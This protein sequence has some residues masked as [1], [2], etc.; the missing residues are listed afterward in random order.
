MLNFDM[1]GRLREDQLMVFGSYS[2]R[3]WPERVDAANTLNLSITLAE[4]LVG[5]SDQFCF[6]LN[7]RPALFLH[8]GLHAQYHTP[9]DDPAL[10][11]EEGMARVGQFALA[12]AVELL[13]R[14]EVP[15]GGGLRPEGIVDPVEV[16]APAT[17]GTAEQVW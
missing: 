3:G 14:T 7:G 17:V 15:E 10:I 8:T 12:L 11:N 2:S 5:R 1:V 9:E 6:L 4:D 16:S 13:T